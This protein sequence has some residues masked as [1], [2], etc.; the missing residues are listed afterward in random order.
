MLELDVEFAR[1]K[2]QLE[3]KQTLSAEISAIVGASGSGKSTL[4]ALVAGLLKPKRGSIKL[5]GKL[6]VDS[7][8]NLWL[9]PHKRH[10]GLVFQDRQ[11]L[12]HLSVRN[13]LRYGYSQLKPAERRFK[14]DDVVG[15][16]E[17]APLLERKPLGLSGGEQ[18]RVALGRAILYAPQLLLLDEPLAALDERLKQQ[19]LPYLLRIN[20]DFKIPMV[21]VTHAQSEVDYLT[22]TVLTMAEGK[23]LAR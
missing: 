15:L 16:L 20:R 3:A 23:L 21:Y 4:L 5:D 9:P 19:I 18:Q 7:T 2:F 8:H 17:L 1:G 11:L 6:L 10:I 13:N 14:L 12:P 22:Q